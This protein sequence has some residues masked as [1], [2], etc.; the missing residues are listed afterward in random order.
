[1]NILDVHTIDTA[2]TG[3]AELFA[4]VARSFGYVPNLYGIFAG[5]PAT[6]KAHMLIGKILDESSFSATEKQLI[7]LAASQHKQSNFRTAVHTV[8]AGIQN[9][10]PDV[11]EA[12][13][14]DRPVSDSRLEALRIFTTT[15]VEKRGWLSDEDVAAFLAAG[16]AKAQILEVIL[17]VWHAPVFT[18]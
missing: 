11:V 6:L 2:P 3:A 9:V 13:R 4:S 14:E 18:A 16:F 17:G 10:P 1:M 12:I 7:I 5:P 8:V 15:V